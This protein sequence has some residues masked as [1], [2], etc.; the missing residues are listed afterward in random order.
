[1]SLLDWG[2]RALPNCADNIVAETH[3]ADLAISLY[4]KYRL[5]CQQQSMSPLPL[6][7]IQGDIKPLLQ[8]LDFRGRFRRQD[9]VVLINQFH[10][11]RSRIA[12]C[13][14]TEYRPREANAIADY[15]AGQ[16]SAFL[17]DLPVTSEQVDSP[18]DVPSDPPYDLLLQANAVILG[19]HQ[20]GKT[21]LIL[22]EMPG[23]D[24]LQM[25]QYA[26]WMDGRS[27]ESNCPGHAPM[28]SPDECGIHRL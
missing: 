3:G 16:A 11:K 12:P 23:C 9:S 28:Q 21:V 25:A 4:E 19:P 18:T 1:M 27:C 13:S 24:L 20:D 26:Q 8:H 5:L 10:A 15:F 22:Q 17:L 6:D 7:H 14:I 2:A